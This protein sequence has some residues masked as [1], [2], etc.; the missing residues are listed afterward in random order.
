MGSI[1]QFL[2]PASKPVRLFWDEIRPKSN[3]VP[4]VQTNNTHACTQK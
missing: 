4:V 2:I 1:S 3:L